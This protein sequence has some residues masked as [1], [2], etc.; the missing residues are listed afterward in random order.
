[1]G[2][3]VFIDTSVFL[4]LLDVPHRNADRTEVAGTFKKDQQ[5][6]ATFV[7][8]VST[9]IETGNHIAQVQ[10]RGNT[11]RGCA[12][13]FVGALKAAVQAQ[14]PWVLTGHA[15]DDD[16]VDLIVHGAGQRPEALLLLCQGV[17]TGDVGILAEVDAYR[18]RIPSATPV[19]IWTLDA[20]LAAYS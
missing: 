14:P 10:G 15:W 18:R 4:N 6:G 8:P 12:Q 5:S 20:G 9:I 13:R 1:M 3:A 11:R 7:L 16:M 2:E 17:G 19:R